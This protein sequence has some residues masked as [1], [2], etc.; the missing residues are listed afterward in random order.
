MRRGRDSLTPTPTPNAGGGSERA[1][2]GGRSALLEPVSGPGDD[3]EKDEV[4]DPLALIRREVAVMKK[5]EW[6]FTS[7]RHN[8]DA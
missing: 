1:Q 2:A 3:E 6:V 8:S 7:I 5:L 4:T